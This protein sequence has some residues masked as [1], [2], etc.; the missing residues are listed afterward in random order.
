MQ[1][2]DSRISK[3]FEGGGEPRAQFS[4]CM[5]CE[6]IWDAKS[7][8]FCLYVLWAYLGCQEHNF[9]FVCIVSIFGMPRTQFSV[10]MYCEHIWDAKSTIFWLFLCILFYL[11]AIKA[12]DI[13]IYFFSQFL[14]LIF[15]KAPYCCNIS[16]MAV[17]EK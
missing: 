14:Y 6:H 4:D 17:N 7:T 15:S 11:A 5:Y 16:D 3:F 9:L 1:D 10:C 8:I 13:Y 12:V 2:L